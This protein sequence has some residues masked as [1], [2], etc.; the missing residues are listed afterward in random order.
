MIRRPPSSAHTDTLFPDTALFLSGDGA[1]LAGNVIETD[2]AREGVSGHRDVGAIEAAVAGGEIDES[3]AEVVGER[4][5]RVARGEFAEPARD[6]AG[7]V[8]DGERGP[9]FFLSSRSSPRLWMLSVGSGLAHGMAAK[10]RQA[11]APE[12]QKEV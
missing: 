10:T 12:D 9:I 3:G 11:L 2:R 8:V 6:A 1:A 7:G 5:G 4:A